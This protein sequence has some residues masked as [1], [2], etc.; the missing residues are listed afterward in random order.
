M[1]IST[2]NVNG[3]NGRLARLLAWL[4]ETAPVL[5]RR[6]VVIAVELI[7]RAKVLPLAQRYF[8]F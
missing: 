1:K 8:L 6:S 2:F 5:A 7:S 4:S 3:V